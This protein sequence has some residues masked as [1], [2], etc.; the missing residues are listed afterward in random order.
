WLISHDVRPNP[1][2]VSPILTPQALVI[3]GLVRLFYGYNAWQTSH[4]VRPNTLAAMV[5]PH[6]ISVR[7]TSSNIRSCASYST[8]FTLDQFPSIHDLQGGSRTPALPCCRKRK[9]R[10]ERTLEA[11]RCSAV[12]A[13]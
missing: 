6:P 12:L 8:P 5:R 10:Q 9:R 11:V 4:H 3:P 1:E 2:N 7:E 13:S